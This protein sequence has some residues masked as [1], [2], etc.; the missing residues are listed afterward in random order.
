[1]RQGIVVLVVASLVA[2]ACSSD[3]ETESEPEPADAEQPADTDPPDTPV[4]TDPA[5]GT[6]PNPDPGLGIDGFGVDGTPG[7]SVS[8]GSVL[9]AVGDLCDGLA[10]ATNEVIV[11]AAS[12]EDAIAILS[13]AGIE[14]TTGPDPTVVEI[15]GL[16]GEFA[17]LEFDDVA[18][19]LDAFQALVDGGI[20]N[21][22]VN[23]VVNFAQ[24][25]RFRPGGDP[26]PT[27]APSTGDWGIVRPVLVLDSQLPTESDLYG[28]RDW[29]YD[30]DTAAYFDGNDTVTGDSGHGPFIASLVSRLVDNG[31]MVRLAGIPSTVVDGRLQTTDADVIKTIALAAPIYAGQELVVNMSFGRY[32]CDTADG[33]PPAP[34]NS[35]GSTLLALDATLGSEFEAIDTLVAA[36]GNDETDG[37]LVPAAFG[38]VTGVGSVDASGNVSCFSNWDKAADRWVVGEDI[39]SE[40]PFAAGFDSGWAEWSGTSFAAAVYSADLAS[41]SPGK[42]ALSAAPTPPTK[43]SGT[44]CAP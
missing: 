25:Y 6:E 12:L 4:D 19:S 37:N 3:D 23:A 33:T 27:A 13:D 28:V 38:F 17:L 40:Y 43:Q 36:A 34:S 29:E 41:D 11:P 1:M 30:G 20:E 35:L 32:A 15:F 16:S 39:V 14:P 31:P 18:T 26:V 5:D 42:V 22:D 9:G 21:V 10:F 44:K 7:S 24:A 8:G 2:A